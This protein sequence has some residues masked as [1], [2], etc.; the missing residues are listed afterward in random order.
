MGS[1][2]QELILKLKLKDKKTTSA[3][4]AGE[5]CQAEGG[6]RARSGEDEAR[7][8]CQ[9]VRCGW[10]DGTDGTAGFAE[11]FRFGLRAKGSA[12]RVLSKVL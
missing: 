7:L 3:H 4:R 6:G 2:S 10:G 8:G 11:G 12:H 1:A 9:G 5:E